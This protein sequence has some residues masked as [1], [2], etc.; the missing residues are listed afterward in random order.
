[1]ILV[2]L[3]LQGLTLIPLFSRLHFPPDPTHAREHAHA[4][5][6]ARRAALE[7]L[8]DLAAEPWAT[9]EALDRVEA[10]LRQ[11]HREAAEGDAAAAHAATVQRLRIATLSARRRELVRLRDEGAISDE[12]L[13]ELEQELDYEALQLGRGHERERGWVRR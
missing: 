12:V 8:A 2:T 1:V 11:A 3:V 13:L 7:H 6:Q 5:A 4:Q 10:D 9:R